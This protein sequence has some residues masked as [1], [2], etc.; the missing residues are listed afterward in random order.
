[1]SGGKSCRKEG[2]VYQIECDECKDIYI[3]ES[4][5][6]GFTRGKEHMQT[7][8]NKCKSSIM[9]RHSK[10]KHK[11]FKGKTKFNMKITGIYRNDPTLRQVTEGT[12]IQNSNQNHL[13]NN[14]T[15]WNSG[16]IVSMSIVRS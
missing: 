5:R 13:I 9:Y 15:E 12:K 6:N 3:G 7:Y 4:A 11:E 16:G 14:K 10:D 2:I 8:K 1:M